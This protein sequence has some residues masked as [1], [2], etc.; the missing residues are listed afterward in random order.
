MYILKNAWLNII[1][2]KGRNILIGII[3][4]IVT[5]G[6]CI[7]ITIN[8]S[9]NALVNTYKSNNPLEVSFNLDTMNFRGATDEVKESF[10]LIDVDFINKVGELDIVNGYYYT[11]QSSLNS[12]SIEAVSYDD[13]FK[14]P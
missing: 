5:I 14:K 4:M 13:L 11:L 1:R 3:I 6:S 9:G 12:D 8:K 10:E 2:S 7:A